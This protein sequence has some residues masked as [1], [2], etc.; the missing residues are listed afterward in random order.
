MSLPP[1]EQVHIPQQQLQLQQQQQLLLLLLQ[2]IQL[3]LQDKESRRLTRSS[4]KHSASFKPLLWG[5]LGPPNIPR[6]PWAP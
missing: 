5:P 6:G 1:P 2:L 4:A 3:L